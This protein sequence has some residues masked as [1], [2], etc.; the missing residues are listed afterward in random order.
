M[1]LGIRAPVFLALYTILLRGQTSGQE[2]AIRTHAYTPPSMIL[3]AETNLVEAD[4]TVRDANGHTIP[5]LQASDF[6]VLDNGIPQ[7]IDSFSIL[8]SEGNASSSEPS[9]T[10]SA[11]R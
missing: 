1:A 2:V 5:G 11:S 10:L 7:K 3:H 9:P 8:R 4:V 6:E